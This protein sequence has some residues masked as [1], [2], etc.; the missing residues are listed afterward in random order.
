MNEIDPISPDLSWL[1]YDISTTLSGEFRLSE[2]GKGGG[3][4][5]IAPFDPQNNTHSKLL[6]HFPSSSGAQ[7]E[8]LCMLP[9]IPKKSPLDV[10]TRKRRR[11]HS[12]SHY[13]DSLEVLKKEISMNTS[14]Q[15]LDP[16]EDSNLNNLILARQTPSVYDRQDTGGS[17]STSTSANSD[18]YF[19]PTHQ[20][21]QRQSS[22]EQSF[23]FRDK[24]TKVS[25]GLSTMTEPCRTFF[26]SNLPGT[27]NLTMRSAQEKK[28]EKCRREKE[29]R[30]QKNDRFEDLKKLL[31]AL[32][33]DLDDKK[34]ASQ[35][36][37]LGAC[38]DLLESEKKFD[39]LPISKFTPK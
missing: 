24:R 23:D 32:I 8:E 20:I 39:L 38:I 12:M 35:G 31:A 27:R 11:N 30:K 13:E 4:S 34:L 14:Q 18:T 22:I 2:D 26:T 29:R 3:N 10:L 25:P 15:V 33:P 37:I 28:T 7:L 9:E 1:G 5:N 16:R 6:R 17:S 21:L 19:T 36:L